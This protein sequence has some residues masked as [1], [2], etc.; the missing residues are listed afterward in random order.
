MFEPPQI[1]RMTF[2][3]YFS[4]TVNRGIT[5]STTLRVQ[6]TQLERPELLENK[7]LFD[8]VNLKMAK[9]NV[10]EDIGEIPP[11]SSCFLDLFED[12]LKK[13]DQ[14]QLL[15][16]AKITVREMDAIVLYALC[17]KNYLYSFY[18]FQ[19]SK[20]FDEKLL[21]EWFEVIEGKVLRIGNA[22]YSD[23]QLRQYI[24]QR[25]VTVV[26]LLEL[27]DQWHCFFY[28]YM[29]LKGE[30]QGTIGSHCHYASEKFNP[31]NSTSE[32]FIKGFKG[33]Y[34]KVSGTPHIPII[35]YGNQDR[36]PK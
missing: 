32:E 24:Q 14:I 29:G 34:Y 15:K 20:G 28:T 25:K 9:E 30:E 12:G 27:G 21:P 17:M 26:K 31:Q 13:K 4:L 11:I 23:G 6:F 33:G 8:K 5:L 1:R 3:E 16:G 2:E 36:N 7:E 10:L 35:D 19:H 22:H 18:S